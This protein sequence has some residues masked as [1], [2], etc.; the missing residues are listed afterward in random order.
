MANEPKDKDRDDAL[1][2]IEDRVAAGVQKGIADY[3]TAQSTTRTGGAPAP[4]TPAPETPAPETPPA[5][6]T[7][8]EL[9]FKD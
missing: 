3:I 8:F 2:M 9:L 6:R 4:E 7:F 5:K 1:K